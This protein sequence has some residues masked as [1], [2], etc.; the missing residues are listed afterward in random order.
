MACGVSGMA[1]VGWVAEGV[2]EGRR[3]GLA[4]RTRDQKDWPRG[5]M[6]WPWGDETRLRHDSI[7]LGLKDS[8][9]KLLWRTGE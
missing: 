4:K 2:G 3:K 6:E 7:I 5:F 1:S 8:H 9:V